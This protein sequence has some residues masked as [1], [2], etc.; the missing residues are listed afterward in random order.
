MAT[1]ALP[2]MACANMAT[3]VLLGVEICEYFVRR[4]SLAIL[5]LLVD[6]PR[7]VSTLFIVHPGKYTM[8]GYSDNYDFYA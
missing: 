4:V 8:S 3:V 5:T 2:V 1:E 7:L 6:T